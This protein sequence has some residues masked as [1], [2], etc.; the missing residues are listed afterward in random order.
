MA[1]TAPRTRPIM[2]KVVL[3]APL[4]GVEDSAEGA[5]LVVEG[6]E[7]SAVPVKTWGRYV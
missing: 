7:T 4:T 3:A 6:G 5:E 1:A 2:E